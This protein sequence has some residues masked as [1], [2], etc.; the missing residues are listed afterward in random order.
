M[1]EEVMLWECRHGDCLT[2]M[3]DMPDGSVDMVL[4]DLPYGTTSCKWDAVIP[5]EQLWDS[6]R[7]VIKP[8]GVIVL[9]GSQPFTSALVMSNI[10][11]FK[12]ALTW[13]K[14]VAPTGHLNAKKMPLRR[15]EDVLVFYRMNST[16]NPQMGSGKP[17]SH[18]AGSNRPSG[19]FGNNKTVECR[20][21]TTR[22]PINLIQFKK[23][24]TRH[25]RLHPTQ[26]PTDLC[27]YLI[28]TYTNAREVV[29]DNC[30]GSGSTG[31]ACINT[32][33]RFIG[34][35]KD[36]YYFNIARTRIRKVCDSVTAVQQEPEWQTDV[37]AAF[38]GMVQTPQ[39]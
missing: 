11:D 27:E 37:Q 23:V 22:Y 17:V 9:F 38:G 32:G 10:I 5:F 28:R 4:C 6:Y 36:E 39:G 26:K 33:R 3:E 35:E 24:Q 31:V 29:L 8:N 2:L 7:R 12:Y 21:V 15:T 20:D 25:G 1:D 16:Y 30:M 13:D 19:V 34:I 18:I 14:L